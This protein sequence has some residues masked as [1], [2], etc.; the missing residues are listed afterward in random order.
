MCACD[1]DDS[2]ALRINELRPGWRGRVIIHC[3]DGPDGD[4]A[5]IGTI[6]GEP[7]VERG[8]EHDGAVDAKATICINYRAGAFGPLSR[9][10]CFAVRASDI[11][12]MQPM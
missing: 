2:L 10:S 11:V 9:H 6:V 3:S 8:L 12:D 5:V 4:I 1:Q 7:S